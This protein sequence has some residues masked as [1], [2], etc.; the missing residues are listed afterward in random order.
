MGDGRCGLCLKYVAQLQTHSSCLCQQQEEE[1]NEAVYEMLVV[2]RLELG[3]FL[4][5][6]CS[7]VDMHPV[8]GFW[9]FYK[10]PSCG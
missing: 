10:H 3:L 5:Y 6:L 7:V 4:D 1:Q 2:I 9:K 8:N